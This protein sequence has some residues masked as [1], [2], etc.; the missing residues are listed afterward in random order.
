[1]ILKGMAP[2]IAALLLTPASASAT[3]PA[4]QIA[5]PADPVLYTIRA[6]D[7]LYVL[8][9]RYFTRIEDYIRVQ[10]LNRVRDPY[11]LPVGRALR[12]PRAM[13]RYEKLAATVIACRGQIEV[14]SGGQNRAVRQGGTVVE[15]DRIFTAENSFI[16]L[17]LPDGSVVSL[18]SRSAVGVRRLRR[19]LLTGGIERLF[20]LEKG[21]ALES[22]TPANNADD[23]FRVSTPVAVSAVRG[24]EFR[25]RYDP[26][27][28]RAVTEVLNGRV[29]VAATETAVPGVTVAA[30]FGAIATASG[31]SG[32]VGLFPAPTLQQP[33][34]VQDDPALRFEIAPLNKASAYHLQIASDAGFLDVI[35]EITTPASSAV[36]PSIPDGIWF[37]RASAIDAD[38]IEGLP[39]IYS[40]QRRLQHIETA[41]DRRRAGRYREYLFR[42]IVEGVG[43][44]QYRFQL[45]KDRPDAT[46]TVDEAGLSTDRFVITDLLPGTYYWR[47]MS[48]Q[49]VDGAAYPKWSPVE[50]LT[51][52]RNE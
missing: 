45:I 15:G 37:V 36:L 35:E 21:Q 11:R 22:V 7:N 9:Q 32:A 40:F 27:T 46:P 33:G 42:W 13:L 12:I 6:G 28:A 19:I 43:A 30:G 3:P 18:P 1:M 39:S 23:S 24:T 8:A 48:L 20:M 44:R 5:A 31:T 52:T 51:I 14:R 17:R 26:D 34:R 4:A 16:S 49:F 38:G 50:R 10:R 41:I 29:R 47:V 25:V 2:V